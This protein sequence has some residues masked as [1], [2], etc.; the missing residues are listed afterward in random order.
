MFKYLQNFFV[1]YILVNSFPRKKKLFS[2]IKNHRRHI[3]LLFFFL[4]IS[5]KKTEIFYKFFRLPERDIFFF[6]SLN[7]LCHK[8]LVSI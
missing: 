4:Y 7:K 2:F 3:D 6:H 5:I 1:F 8:I